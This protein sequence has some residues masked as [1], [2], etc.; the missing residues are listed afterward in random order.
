MGSADVSM[1]F[2]G[3][4]TTSTTLVHLLRCRGQLGRSLWPQSGREGYY[5]IL[6]D[7][8]AYDAALI[9]LARLLGVECGAEEFDLPEKARARLEGTL[10]TRG[11]PLDEIEVPARVDEASRNG[12]G[13]S[14]TT[15]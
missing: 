5:V 7:H 9:R 1:S 15:T 6:I 2:D 8:L 14:L 12:G 13:H 11:I 4:P 3:E 10:S